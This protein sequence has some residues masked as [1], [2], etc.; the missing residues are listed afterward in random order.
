MTCGWGEALSC[1]RTGQ[2]QAPVGPAG[3]RAAPPLSLGRLPV[4][5]RVVLSAVG[6]GQAEG[7]RDRGGPA[8]EGG[9]RTESAGIGGA[10]C[11]RKLG[12]SEVTGSFHVSLGWG[13]GCAFLWKKT[14]PEVG[15]DGV[16]L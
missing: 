8:V 5:E 16:N 6:R 13:D 15:F 14:S 2:S 10:A 11:G 9:A 12:S 7:T 3:D 4:R 1:S